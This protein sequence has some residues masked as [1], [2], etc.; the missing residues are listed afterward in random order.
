MSQAF[1]DFAPYAASAS[2]P[3]RLGAALVL[4]WGACLLVL[5]VAQR[6]G[7]PHPMVNRSW[8]I[9]GTVVA[10]MALWVAVLCGV[11]VIAGT[12]V[13]ELPLLPCALTLLFAGAA[14]G[15][16]LLAAIRGKGAQRLLGAAAGGG[17]SM[18]TISVWAES[19][20]PASARCCRKRRWSG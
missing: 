5:K 3:L 4:A 8:A 2:V 10:A 15:V 12:G 11:C 20:L 17:C 9:V 6:A 1:Y 7:G 14:I 18:A 13:A 16:T 19:S